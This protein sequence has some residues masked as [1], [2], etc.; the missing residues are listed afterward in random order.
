MKDL[1]GLKE[2]I[3]VLKEKMPEMPQALVKAK[4]EVKAE[5]KPLCH[6]IAYVLCFLAYLCMLPMMLLG[7]M[8]KDLSMKCKPAEKKEEQKPEEAPAA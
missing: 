7:A 5:C 2:D 1:K 6:S 8:F 3:K 4:D